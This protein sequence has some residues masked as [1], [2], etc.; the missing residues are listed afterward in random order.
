MGCTYAA[1]P[2]S[3]VSLNAAFSTV[4]AFGTTLSFH[5]ED[6]L[7]IQTHR[8]YF[9]RSYKQ[10]VIKL[11][12]L[13]KESRPS[14]HITGEM[15]AG[16]VDVLQDSPGKPMWFDIIDDLY[17]GKTYIAQ[18]LRRSSNAKYKALP[19]P[20]KFGCSRRS[21]ELLE[22]AHDFSKIRVTVCVTG[23]LLDDWTKKDSEPLPFPGE[24][25]LTIFFSAKQPSKCN[26][27]TT[28]F[29]KDLKK[30]VTKQAKRL[31]V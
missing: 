25:S 30:V 22:I 19:Y 23:M 10:N 8:W 27:A 13:F 15:H 11:I 29:Q 24:V 20:D 4:S 5:A 2:E 9:K 7:R 14:L 31:H 1:D 18:V 16:L 17:K 28:T 3:S 26:T 12:K 6:A 21:K